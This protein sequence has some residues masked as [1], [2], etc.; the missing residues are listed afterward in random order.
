MVN[1]KTI[2]PRKSFGQRVK[3]ELSRHK[4]LYLMLI[5]VA[6][7]YI[8]FLYVPMYG[9]IIAFKDYRPDLGILGSPWVGLKHFKDFFT[10]IY[11]WRVIRNTLQI[12]LGT[13]LFGFPA[14][15]ILALLLN[16]IRSKMFKKSVQTL[17]YLPH[18]IST[19][20][21][22][23]IIL[24]FTATDGVINSII[25]ALGFEPI[26][27]MIR[28]EWFQ[29][30]YIGTTIWQQVGWDSIIY[31]A[32]LAGIDQQLYEACRIDGG[33]RLRQLLT[34]TLPGILPTI[35][36]MLIMNAGK[37]MSIGYEKILLLYNSNTYETADIIS[38]FVYRRGIV[39]MNYSFASAV[40]L[41]N[42]VINLILLVSVNRICRKMTDNSLW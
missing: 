28:E 10:S 1:K 12:S 13:L 38:S 5:P 42:S 8:I 25:T 7:Y 41:F 19:V 30:I 29:P 23:S 27:F 3:V 37:I 4:Y 36:V 6:L 33:G 34:V 16:E 17:T 15:I 39:D 24:N 22:C 40:G 14:P 32:A 31:I 35:V 9:S 20:V 26:Q 11:A 18:F 21:I 2:K